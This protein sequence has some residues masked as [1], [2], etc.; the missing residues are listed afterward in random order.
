M[1]RCEDVLS[2]VV[3]CV[4]KGGCVELS[5]GCVVCCDAGMC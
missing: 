1:L 5:S 4:V 3:L 2:C